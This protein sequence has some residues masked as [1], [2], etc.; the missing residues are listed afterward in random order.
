MIRVLIFMGVVFA[1]ALG[2]AWVAERPGI[3]SLDWQGYRIEMGVMTALVIIAAAFAV[4]HL[5][6]GALRTVLRSPDIAARFWRRRK[7]DR[8]YDALSKGLVALG[9]GDAPSA[10]RYGAEAAKLLK[11]EP[12]AKLLLAQTAQLSGDREEARRRFEDMLEDPRLKAVGL[13]GLFIEAERLDEPVAARHYAEEA[14]EL[15]PGLPWA[16]R[17]VLGYQAMGEDWEKAQRTLERNYAARLIDKKTFRR[18]KAVIMTARAMELEDR[19][20]DHARQLAYEAH[21]L[22]PDLVPAAALAARLFTRRGEIRKTL[23]IVETTWKA[24][25]HPDLAEAYAHARTGDSAQDRLARVK[26]LA[27]LRPNSTDGALAVATAAIEASDWGLAREKLA[28]VLRSNPARR[29]CLLMAELEEKENGDRGRVREW[30][31]RAVRAPADPTWVADGIVS[32]EW[33]PVSPLSGRLD[34][35]EWTEPP[36]AHPEDELETIDESLLAA[37]PSLPE[38]KPEPVVKPRVET[39][40]ESEAETKPAPEPAK[41]AQPGPAE[42]AAAE[43]EPA[44]AEIIAPEKPAAQGVEARPTNKAEAGEASGDGARRDKAEA[45]KVETIDFP[46]K[47][48]PDDPGPEEKEET[49][50]KG[51]FRF[52]N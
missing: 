8:G 34:A 40:A 48:M 19:E 36:A 5:L 35:F 6:W 41:D 9:V 31:S 23:K 12:A 44:E 18:H 42:S 52:F 14:A 22:A 29:A 13:H 4:V 20:P 49:A 24:K 39:P 10:K 50:A 3:I 1:L 38:K 45:G 16:G 26:S 32:D 17:A 2:A 33:A 28:S 7:K 25:P 30:L 15:V 46:L 51:G 43:K 37:L 47:H 11:G 27:A 21:G